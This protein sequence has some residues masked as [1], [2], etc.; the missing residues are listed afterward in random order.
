MISMQGD[1]DPLMIL[2]RLCGKS[3]TFQVE[4]TPIV[5][6]QVEQAYLWFRVHPS[7]EQNKPVSGHTEQHLKV[8]RQSVILS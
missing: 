4:L 5:E 2:L 7:S 6:T 3:M 8:L 1:F